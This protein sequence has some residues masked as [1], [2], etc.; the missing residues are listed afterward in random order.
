MYSPDK[1][2]A[3]HSD[4]A[5]QKGVDQNHLEEQKLE[6]HRQRSNRKK[7]TLRNNDGQPRV[8]NY[9]RVRNVAN[10]R[11]SSGLNNGQL[12]MSRV[13]AEE[14]AILHVPSQRPNLAG[15]STRFEL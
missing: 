15:K 4:A 14:S 3:R 8:T 10:S 12:P 5:N 2:S 1:G 13:N 6:V 9:S 11:E 7:M